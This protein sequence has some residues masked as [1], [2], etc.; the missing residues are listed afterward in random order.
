ML[1]LNS[2]CHCRCHFV[3]RR[4]NLNPLCEI[5]TDSE[6]VAT[7][8]LCNW[9]QRANEINANHIPGSFNWNGMKLR[10]SSS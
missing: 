3:D 9:A 6:D 1:T 5:I 4:Y 8:V 10:H 2:A 7:S